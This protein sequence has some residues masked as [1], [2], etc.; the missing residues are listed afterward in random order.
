M[1][2]PW[3]NESVGQNHKGMRLWVEIGVLR[4]SEKRPRER[5]EYRKREE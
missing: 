3:H 2:T 4:T 1:N 5:S